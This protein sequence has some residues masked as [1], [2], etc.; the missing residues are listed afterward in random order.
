MVKDKPKGEGGQKIPRPFGPSYRVR[1]FRFGVWGG[2]GYH[3]VLMKILKRIALILIMLC[4]LQSWSAPSR[5]Q[6]PAEQ[7]AELMSRMSVEDKV[8]QL[9][10][11]PF[12]GANANPDAAITDANTNP[13]THAG[14]DA[15]GR[16]DR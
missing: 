7:V 9:F 5:A 4:C 15:D 11:V 10:I 14:P 8:G 3:G 2:L 12:V 1:P 13:H 16:S 6:T